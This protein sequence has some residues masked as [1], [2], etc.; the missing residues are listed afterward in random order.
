MPLLS[1]VIKGSSPGELHLV[2]LRSLPASGPGRG[3]DNGAAEEIL[4]A[5][6]SQASQMIENARSEA[7]RL[8]DEA[9]AQARET[10][11]NSQGEAAAVREKAREEGRA[12]GRAEAAAES[13][14]VLARAG[15]VLA[16]AEGERRTLLAGLPEELA[17]L[18][19]A[20]AR[21][22][23]ARELAQAPAAVTAIA[24]EALELVKNRE[25]VTVYVNPAEADLFRARR[26][27]LEGS[28]SDRAVLVIIADQDVPAGGLLVETEQG[29]VDA[30]LEA[31][32]AALR[33]ALGSGPAKPPAGV[34]V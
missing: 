14:A 29:L 22:V 2:E 15:Q 3:D 4:A 20:I 32:F 25:R 19:L 23:V 13:A 7:A 33:T 27:D 17:E 12:A 18:A 8:L 30:T 31:R 11:E 6:G 9:A 24:R 21:Q 34:P 5:A 1:R 16:Q 26:G 28:L 10:V